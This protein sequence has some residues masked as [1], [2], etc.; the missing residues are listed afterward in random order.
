LAAIFFEES[1]L[2]QQLRRLRKATGLTQIRL[3]ARAGVS[4]YRVSLAE[5]GQISLR[6]QEIAALYAVLGSELA[7]VRRDIETFENQQRE[8]LEVAPA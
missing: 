2:L 3:A 7:A 5:S 6:P 8:A 1:I 4:H